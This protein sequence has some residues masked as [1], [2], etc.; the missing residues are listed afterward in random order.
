MRVIRRSESG[1][2]KVA[3]TDRG[4]DYT[5]TTIMQGVCSALVK[6]ATYQKPE[7]DDDENDKRLPVSMR[8]DLFIGAIYYNSS[9]IR[10]SIF[11]DVDAYMDRLGISMSRLVQLLY[12]QSNKNWTNRDEK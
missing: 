4:C 9:W 8:I 2:R 10:I 11:N 7:R 1:H 5:R 12:N 3:R 6:E